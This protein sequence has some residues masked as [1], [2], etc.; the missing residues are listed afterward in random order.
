MTPNLNLFTK[1]VK[2]GPVHLVRDKPQWFRDVTSQTQRIYAKHDI[3]L[4]S[5][6]AYVGMEKAG[7]LAANT[8][9]HLHEYIK[10]GISTFDIHLECKNYIEKNNGI[11]TSIGFH[12]FPSSLCT[13]V[14][15]VACHGIAK[16][17]VILKEGDI[18][19]CDVT[20]SLNGF[21]GDTCYTYFVN[22]NNYMDT[23]S[24]EMAQF[25]YIS[26]KSRDIGIE[27]S[28]NGKNV[29]DIGFNI[30][31][32][33]KQVNEYNSNSSNESLNNIQ[34]KILSEYTGHGIGLNIHEGPKNIDHVFTNIDKPIILI[35]GMFITIEPIIMLNPLTSIGRRY[36]R[37]DKNDQWTVYVDNVLSA[38]FE[39]TIGIN[40]ELY[41]N[42]YKIFTTPDDPYPNIWENVLKKYTGKL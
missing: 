13:S 1:K 18:I 14:N 38:Q 26:Q 12:G 31:N 21:H 5:N 20:C 19:K 16:K 3:S 36:S 24:Y 15:D 33:I 9:R 34:Y 17:D 41:D 23:M 35:N 2:C 25:L 39:H 6:D 37:I 7:K 11:P 40:D 29:T 32:Y 28:L 4:Y 22:N 30:E 27:N 10:P 8:L 42:G